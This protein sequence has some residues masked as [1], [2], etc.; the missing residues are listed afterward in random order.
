VDLPPKE[1]IKDLILFSVSDE[2]FRL[3]K[4]LG[5]QIPVS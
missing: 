4:L 2:Y 3:R 5:I 1:K